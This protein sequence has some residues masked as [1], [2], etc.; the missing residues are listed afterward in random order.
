MDLLKNTVESITPVNDDMDAAILAHINDLTKP[1]GSLGELEQVAFRFARIN[2][3]IKPDI[4]LK[5][6]YT[7]AADHGVT[8]QG[9]SAFPKEVTVQMVANMLGGG[10]AINVFGKHVGCDVCVVDIG[11]DGD[12]SNMKGLIHRKIRRGTANMVN[13]AAMSRDEAVSAIEVGIDLANAAV[14]DGITLIGTG[15]MGIGNTTPSAALMHVLLP[16]PLKDIVGRGTGVDD[17]GM[18]RK[19]DTIRR[20]VVQHQLNDENAK[21][22]DPIDVLSRIGGLEIAGIAG[23]LLG[24]AANGICAVVDGFISSAGA[25]LACRISPHVADYLFF[26][27]LSAE[28]GHQMFMREMQLRPLLNLG[29]RLGEG[30]GA[31]LAMGLVDASVKMLR[32]MATF[33]SA[34]VSGEL[35]GSDAGAA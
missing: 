27:H 34:G 16:C 28:Q 4:P 31:A 22:M 2:R 18:Q 14:K 12:L 13:T 10:A 24:C 32:E 19:T 26:S 29:F 6:L 20:A 8:E 30:T 21:D 25:L 33:S 1:P 23:L 3:Q 5:R 11:V 9:V 7:F 17:A 15:E 35:E